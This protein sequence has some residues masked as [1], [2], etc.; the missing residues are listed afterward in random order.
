M[1]PAIQAAVQTLRT[2]EPR[3]ARSFDPE[4]GTV[5][6]WKMGRRADGTIVG[7]RSGKKVWVSSRAC[8]LVAA[9]RAANRVARIERSVRTDWALALDTA[10]VTRESLPALRS[11]AAAALA[12][13][14]TARAQ[15]RASG[16]EGD[17]DAYM[18][19]AET[20]FEAAEALNAAAAQVEKTDAGFAQDLAE[21]L[22]A[23]VFK[24]S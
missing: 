8:V 16:T 5:E 10:A 20:S 14:A 19:A 1:S 9:E 21:R 6:I 15:K 17:A 24:R 12:T 4:T 23:S 18:V 13:K 11:A 2:L 3:K 7:L 22:A